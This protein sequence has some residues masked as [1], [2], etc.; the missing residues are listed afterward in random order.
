LIHVKNSRRG[1]SFR[2][3][4]PLAYGAATIYVGAADA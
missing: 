4:K 2:D 1:K 3:A